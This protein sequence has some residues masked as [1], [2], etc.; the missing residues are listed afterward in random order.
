MKEQRI[1]IEIDEEGRIRADADGFAGDTCL[2]ELE[3]LLEGLSPGV[4]S[5]AAFGNAL[6]VAGRDAA[7]VEA[8]IAPYRTQAGLDWHRTDAN[9]EDVFI[10]LIGQ[11]QDNYALAAA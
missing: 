5:V 4:L 6:H 2:R 7:Q 9:L 1:V 11:A 10:S 8:A 3:K